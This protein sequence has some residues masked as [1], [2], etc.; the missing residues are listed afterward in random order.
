MLKPD[1]EEHL[2]AGQSTRREMAWTKDGAG[3]GPVEEQASPVDAGPL[4]Q[5]MNLILL[6]VVG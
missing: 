3:G 4:H 1:L 5:P 2:G 6:G